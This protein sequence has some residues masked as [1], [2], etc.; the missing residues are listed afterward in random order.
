MENTNKTPETIK[1][2]TTYA[3]CEDLATATNLILT[4]SNLLGCSIKMNNEGKFVLEIVSNV[5]AE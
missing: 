5:V 4:E 3:L 1:R 2:L